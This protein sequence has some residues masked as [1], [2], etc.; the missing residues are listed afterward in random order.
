MAASSRIYS[1]ADLAEMLGGAVAGEASTL[2]RGVAVFG[3]AQPGDIT[4][5]LP[6]GHTHDLARTRASAVICARDP[7]EAVVPLIHVDDPRLAFQ[8]LVRLFGPEYFRPTLGVHPTSV[9]AADAVFGEGVAVGPQCTI[10]A[11]ARIGDRAI[12]MAGCYLGVRSSVGEDTVLYPGVTVR[13]GCTVG[14]CCVVHAGAVIG[15]DGFGYVFEAG[16]FQKVPQI[17]NVVVDRDVEIGAHTSID[18]AATDTTRVGTGTKIANLVQI[19]HNVVVGRHCVI[20]AQAGIAGSTELEDSVVIGE[21]AALNDHIRIGQGVEISARGG[22]PR[23]VPANIAL[24]GSPVVPHRLFLRIIVC[25]RK[26]PQM[27]QRI[28]A[29]ER[30]VTRLEEPH[31]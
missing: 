17:G 26:L 29:L 25:M 11:G 22:V 3:E 5:L 4:C 24:S 30:R 23:S 12:I 13:E 8:S 9:V 1:L 21:R 20:R 31:R 16:R 10:E 28:T 18:R 27:F 6:D 7:R 14:A 2:I 15:A 19:G